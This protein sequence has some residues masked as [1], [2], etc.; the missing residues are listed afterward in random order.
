M[1]E[2]SCDIL[3]ISSL[4]HLKKNFT[5]LLVFFYANTEKQKKEQAAT[6]F[7]AGYKPAYNGG[8]PNRAAGSCSK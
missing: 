1:S 6:F 4:L 3:R 7:K 2:M 5:I 8:P